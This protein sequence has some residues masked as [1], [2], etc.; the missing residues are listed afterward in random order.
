MNPEENINLSKD[1]TDA[2]DTLKN[3]SNLT[4][5]LYDFAQ[6]YSINT[7]TISTNYNTFSKSNSL[8][9]SPY[10]KEFKSAADY[11]QRFE[12]EVSNFSDLIKAVEKNNK[13]N[14]KFKFPM[15][16]SRRLQMGSS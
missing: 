15:A 2:L 6:Q 12:I 14:S 13:Q 9:D 7:L 8:E 3:N 4:E 10:S 5:K 1:I 11:F 16:R